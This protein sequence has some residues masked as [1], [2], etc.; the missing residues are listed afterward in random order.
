MN[1]EGRD[2][3]LFNYQDKKQAQADIKKPDNDAIRF[4]DVCNSCKK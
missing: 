4:F 3:F 1:A 2:G